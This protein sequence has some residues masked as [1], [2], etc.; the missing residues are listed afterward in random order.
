MRIEFVLPEPREPQ[1]EPVDV[2]PPQPTPYPPDSKPNYDVPAIAGPPARD[3]TP[4]GAI[5]EHRGPSYQS[6]TGEP[7]PSVFDRPAKSGWM[8]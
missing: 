5:Y 3:V 2:T 1:P 6:Q 4:T 8:K 7:M